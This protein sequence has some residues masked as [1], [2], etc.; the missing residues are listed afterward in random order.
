MTWLPVDAGE[1]AERDAVLGLVPESYDA[2]RRG[3]EAVWRIADARLIEL[4]RLRLAQLAEARAEL[5]GADEELLDEL[6]AWESSA[7][8][9]ERERAVLSYTEQYYYDHNNLS[10]AQK[11]ELARHF[12]HGEIV[13]FVWAMHMNY[14]Y[15]RALSL[16]DIAPDPPGAPP[17][18]ERL[19]PPEGRVEIDP[20]PVK[21]PVWEPVYWEL[22]AVVVRQPLADEVTSEA[23]RL[24]NANHQQCHY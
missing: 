10:S 9:T 17:R 14:A 7:L 2:L 3:L 12:T 20:R 5:A 19:P 15:I 22:A 24:H 21:S 23:V 13:N 11:E 16:L 6:E 18:P 1:L 4:C 8:F